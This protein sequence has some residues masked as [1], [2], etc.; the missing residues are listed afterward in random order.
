M[1]VTSK[2]SIAACKALMGSI[3]VTMTRAPKPRKEWARAFA[4]V[5]VA[6]DHGDL[7]GD[8]DIGGAL[9]AVGQRFAAAVKI[10]ELGF[11]DGVVDVDGG[12]EQFA[13]FLHLVK[14]MDAGGGFFADALPVLDDACQKA[15]RS[16]CTRL[17]RFL[18]TSS[19]C[20]AL[21]VLTQSL[22]FSNS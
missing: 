2:P 15:G 9:D 11:G 1:V 10:V 3:S 14:A 6:A 5:A 8:H 13:R 12:D 20:E 7:A 16:L 22:P 18:M 17:R 21:G 4:D 19:S